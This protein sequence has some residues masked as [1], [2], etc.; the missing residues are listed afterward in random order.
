MHDKETPVSIESILEGCRNGYRPAE[1]QLF[2]RY[3]DQVYSLILRTLGGAC[4]PDEVAQQVFIRIFRS[5]VHFKG[6]SSFDTWVYRITAKTCI[7]QMRIKYRKRKLQMV[8]GGTEAVEM[9]AGPEEHGPLH[10]SE[11]RELS[12]QIRGALEKLEPEKRM[13]VI[14]FDIQG[15]SISEVA[16]ILKTPPGTVKSRLFHARR[17]LMKHLKK[18]V[19]QT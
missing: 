9:L 6:L 7:D 2:R 18:Y 13:A 15:L 5:L 17:E 16:D 10:R 3:R 19:D 8:H 1:R 4:D 14:L 12:V 11:R